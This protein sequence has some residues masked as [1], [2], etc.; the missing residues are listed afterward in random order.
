MAGPMI[1]D[2][3][4]I[5]AHR[6]LRAAAATTDHASLD[7]SRDPGWSST[8]LAGGEVTTGTAD[9]EPDPIVDRELITGQNPKSDRL[10]AAGL[11]EA[12]DRAR[13]RAAG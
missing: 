10:I 11:V 4:A 2:L 9:F 3:E 12:L 5:V 8:R 13:V 6:S 1:A 7:E